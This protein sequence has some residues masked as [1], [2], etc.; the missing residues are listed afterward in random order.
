MGCCKKSFGKNG[1][2]FAVLFA[3]L[4]VLCFFWY[5]TISD[6]GL[7]ELYMNM[8]R[9]SFMWFSGMNFASFI[10]G[11]VQVYILGWVV[12]LA[13]KIAGLC[14]GCCKD[15]CKIEEKK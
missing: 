9:M 6:A 2:F 4:Y 10:S 3:L 12:A 5:Y 11:L 7:K 14:C 1:M 15:E 13:I 8:H